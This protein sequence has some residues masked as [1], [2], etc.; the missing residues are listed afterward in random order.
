MISRQKKK[1]SSNN[2][3]TCQNQISLA[4]QAKQIKIEAQSGENK[5]LVT[6]RTSYGTT[7]TII[8]EESI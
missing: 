7:V 8:L 1:N 2:Y 4:C 6:E 3:L 5:R